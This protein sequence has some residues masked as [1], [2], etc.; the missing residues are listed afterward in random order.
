MTTVLRAVASVLVALSLVLGAAGTAAAADPTP[1]PTVGGQIDHIARKSTIVITSHGNVPAH[2]T[3]SSEAVGLSESS[4]DL[5]PEAS[6][7]VTY[8]GEP[9]G[10]VVARFDI[11][12]SPDSTGDLG[13]AELVLGLKPYTP[14]FDPTVPVGIVVILAALALIT[15]RLKPW[16]LRVVRA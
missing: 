13:S 4:F 5:Q 1:A 3:L 15:R 6:H 8:T 16:R 11:I 12:R 14:P 10:S 9:V 7:T 2:V